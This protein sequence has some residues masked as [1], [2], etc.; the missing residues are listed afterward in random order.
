MSRCSRRALLLF[1]LAPLVLAACQ[2]PAADQSANAALPRPIINGTS[3]SD[4]AHEAILEM[5]YE[6][7]GACTATL[8]TDT[9]VLTAAHCDSDIGSSQ[10]RG[11]VYAV[12]DHCNALSQSLQITYYRCFISRQQLRVNLVNPKLTTN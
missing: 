3:S 2:P 1:A 12:T 8:I 11:V 10:C 7:I 6:G 9:V 4:A 5:F